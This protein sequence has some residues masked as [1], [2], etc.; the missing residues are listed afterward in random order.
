MEYLSFHDTA[1]SKS[2]FNH[3]QLTI[4]SINHLGLHLQKKDLHP[5]LKGYLQ[6]E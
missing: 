3:Q 6:L 5:N 1:K 4:L 2:G